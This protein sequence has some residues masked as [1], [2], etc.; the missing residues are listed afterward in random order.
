MFS[1]YIAD[2]NYS[3]WSMRAWVLLKSARI[4]FQERL[5]R[6]AEPGT[7]EAIGAVSPSGRLPVLHDGKLRIW[8][9]LAIIEYVDDLYPEAGV[10]PSSTN[11]RAVARSVAAEMH[12]GFQAL[13]HHLPM[14][15]R[16]RFP[17]HGRNAASVADIARIVEIW[18]HNLEAFGGPYLY[19]GEFLASD[20]MFAPVVTRFV[21]YGVEVPAACRAYMDTVLA[22][23]AVAE[24]V[25]DARADPVAIERLDTL[26]A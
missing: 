24:W 6:L 13:R 21:T 10:W 17:G 9:S 11:V 7:A 3:S 5:I 15:I 8:D 20:A 12:S 25:R 4:P 14:N 16:A 26:P 18:Q 1:L 19:G 2:K 23:P 22:H